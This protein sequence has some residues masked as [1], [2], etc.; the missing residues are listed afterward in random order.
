MTTYIYTLECP[1]KHTIIY[2]G[3]TINIKE[4]YHTVQKNL[5]KL[6]NCTLSYFVSIAF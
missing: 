2:V 1:I 6:S 4:R 5:Q 3:K